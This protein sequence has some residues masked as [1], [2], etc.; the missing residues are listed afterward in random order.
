MLTFLSMALLVYG[1]MHLYTLG[2]VW[3]VFPHS[4]GLGLALTLAGIALTFSP[5]IVWYMERQGWHGATVVTAWAIYTWMGFLFLFFC[6][7]LVFDLARALASLLHFKH[8]LSESKAF[9]IAG[10]L[11]LAALGYGFV[12]ARQIQIEEIKITT[13]KLA[14][15][16]ITLAQ[17]SDLH[18][19]MMAGDAFLERII[20]KLR[21][22]KPDI[23]VATGDIVDGH[24][25]NLNALARRFHDYTPPLGAYAVATTNAMPG[26]IAPCISCAAQASPCCAANR[27]QQAE[28]YWQVSMIQPAHGKQTS[29]P[30]WTPEKL[31]PQSQQMAQKITSSSCSNTS[32]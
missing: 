23:V 11:A 21:E 8:P 30:G 9:K 18:L 10:L 19:G 22:I 4:F 16:R 26:W 20:A 31:S 17:I 28:S 27:S 3:R 5:F 25:D 2:K 1:S 13:P 32:R 15:G 24:G 12:E 29:K 6:I 7:G 14:S